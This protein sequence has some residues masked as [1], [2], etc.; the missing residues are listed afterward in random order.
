MDEEHAEGNFG[1]GDEARI[2]KNRLG[3]AQPETGR[4]ND[5]TGQK[6]GDESL[7]LVG[8]EIPDGINEKDQAEGNQGIHSNNSF[9]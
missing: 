5:G 6:H 2:G 7:C 3:K 9:L 1:K 8:D 4:E